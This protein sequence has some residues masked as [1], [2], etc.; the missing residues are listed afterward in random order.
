MQRIDITKAPENFERNFS[1]N[2]VKERLLF[3]RKQLNLTQQEF[4]EKLG[5]L[6]TTVS[7]YERGDIV[8][9][10]DFYRKLSKVFNLDLNWLITG[11]GYSTVLVKELIPDEILFMYKSVAA[12]VLRD[13]LEEF[14]ENEGIDRDNLRIFINIETDISLKKV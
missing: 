3:Y 6:S 1:G 8:P 14:F 9:A 11:V 12:D 2:S 10:T 5:V 4:A 7:K 13:S